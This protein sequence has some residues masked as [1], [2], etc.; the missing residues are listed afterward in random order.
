MMLSLVFDEE[1]ISA[2]AGWAEC[3][4]IDF[5]GCAF[6]AHSCPSLEV[7]SHSKTEINSSTNHYNFQQSSLSIQFPSLNIIYIIS[8]GDCGLWLLEPCVSS[9]WQVCSVN[10]CSDRSHLICSWNAMPSICLPSSLL[11]I[12][13]LISLSL[14]QGNGSWRH[15]GIVS[16]GGKL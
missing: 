16:V 11:W 1:I 4:K 12:V 9:H 13:R 15:N 3:F 8:W 5:E 7:N 14:Q 6:K 10:T 2:Q